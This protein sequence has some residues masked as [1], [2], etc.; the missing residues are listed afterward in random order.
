M[1]K[2]A[3]VGERRLPTPRRPPDQMI[4]RQPSTAPTPLTGL[5]AQP[6]PASVGQPPVV[7]AT[8]IALYAL[9]Y[10]STT[11]LF[12]APALVSLALKVNDLVGIEAAP[13]NLSMVASI[14]AALS[15]VANPVFGHLS[16]RTPGRWG[17]RRPWMVLGLVVGSTGIL[18]I[19]M[20]PNIAVVAAG[21]CVAQVFYNA[22]LAAQVAV[23]ADQVPRAQRGMVAG[24]LG[25]CLPLGSIC[26]TFLV[27]LFAPNI[28]AMLLGPCALAAVFIVVFVVVLPDRRLQPGDVATR[29]SS[30]RG[31]WWRTSLLNPR[32]HPDF[33]WAFLSKFLF[34][35]A[36]AFLTTYQAYYLIAHLGS[37]ESEVPHQVF[38]GALAQGL[39]VIAASLTGGRLSDATGRRKVFVLVASAVF[40]VAMFVVAMAGEFNGFVAGMALS[41]LGLGLYVAVDLALVVDVLPDPDHVA[42]DLGLFNIAGAVPFSLAPVVAPLILAL[43]DDSYPLLFA[44]AGGSAVLGALAILPV[45]GVR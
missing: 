4:S 14:G 12:L 41:G 44:V 20:A 32:A 21:W 19:A 11:L 26:G 35:M 17:M 6:A 27:N 37:P 34:V 36:Y 31:R 24:V 38:L 25:I 40:A 42:K 45:R 18:L 33:T 2:R 15:I 7:S 29:T 30:G 13:K 39:V 3:R 9:A 22:L 23:L 43:G 8:F 16:D 5:P 28:S 10:M 1:L